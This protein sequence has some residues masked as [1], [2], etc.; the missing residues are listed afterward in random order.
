MRRSRVA[1]FSALGILSIVA[2]A[3]IVVMTIDLGRY[4]GFTENLVSD[5]LGRRFEIRGTFK[6]ELGRKIL[7]V[8][9]D[10]HLESGDWTG[11][12]D[13]MSI[14]HLDS[15]IDALSFFQGPIMIESLRVSDARVN[16]EKAADGQ[17]NWTF[18]GGTN[19]PEEAA[20]DHQ[21]PRLGA[22]P[23]MIR[24]L[25]IS[26]F[27]LSYADP[28]MQRPLAISVDKLT[29]LVDD[30][31]EVKLNLAGA[32]N[33]TPFSIAAVAA[34]VTRLVSLQEISATLRGDL[35]EIRFESSAEIDHLLAPRLP[36]LKLLVQG[37][38]AEY[39]TDVIGIER[40][41]TGPLRLDVSVTPSGQ[42]LV[43][44]ALGN[45]GEFSVD[46]KGHVVDLGNF[47]DI[48]VEAKA[49]GP[50][51]ATIGKLLGNDNFPLDPY[52]LDVEATI[53]GSNIQ[54][55]PLHIEIGV[56]KL[57]AS[58]SIE[59]FPSPDG[60]SAKVHVSG[61]DFGKFNKL[62]GLPGR[63]TGPFSLDA[64]V[65]A[66]PGRKADVSLNAKAHDLSLS[67]KG[68]WVDA[69]GFAGSTVDITASGPRFDTV[70][71]TLDVEKSPPDAFE[72]Q[73][74]LEK[75]QSSSAI[76][77]GR[78]R[79]GSDN[80]KITG[81][82]G[83][84]PLRS[85]TNLQ[86]ELA[87]P[88][89]R[90]TLRS[91][92]A[93]AERLPATEWST[94]G[95]IQWD[96]G[97]LVLEQVHTIIGSNREYLL[98]VESRVTEHPSYLGS[99]AKISITGAEF[100]AVAEVGGVLKMPDAR[101]QVTG[102][103]ERVANGYSVSDGK[104]QLGGDSIGIN[105][106]IGDRPLRQGT[107]VT[108]Q[109]SIAEFRETLAS[110][111]LP[112]DNVPPGPLNARGRL[113]SQGDVFV[114]RNVNAETSDAILTATGHLGSF[115]EL[116]GTDV[117]LNVTGKDLSR[118][119]PGNKALKA[120][121]NSFS[122]KSKIQISA[123]EVSFKGLDGKFD[124]S[125]LRGAASVSRDPFL[126]HGRFE[127]HADT[128]DF[129]L[130]LQRY[131]GQVTRTGI[132]MTLVA[133]GDWDRN[134]WSFDNF[135]FTLGEG[136]LAI[137]GALDGPPGFERTDL[138]VD[139][140]V[141]NARN[142][143]PIVDRDFPE[144]SIDLHARLIGATDRMTLQ[145]FAATIGDSEIDGEFSMRG[146]AKP[147][148][149]IRMASK[150]LDLSGYL[151][152]HEESPVEPK[153]T[154]KDKVLPDTP[155]NLE[156]LHKLNGKVDVR[157]GEL[158]MPRRTVRNIVLVGTLDD[159]LMKV[160]DFKLTSPGDGSL[161]A[162]FVLQDTGSGA[163]VTLNLAGNKL[164]LGLP[165]AT[166]DEVKSLPL[167]DVD[168][169]LQGS[170]DTVAQLAGSLNGFARVVL[171]PGKVRATAMGMFTQ[172]F[173]SQVLN[174]V[175]PFARTDPYTNVKCAVLLVEARDGNLTGDPAL[176][177]QT[178]K[179][180]IFAKADIKLKTE[181]LNVSVNTVPQTGLGL[182]LSNLVTPLTQISGTLAKPT[183]ALDA[184]GAIIQG[185]AAV[186]TAGISFLATR[187]R[188]RYLSEKDAC[189]KAIGDTQD[190]F[191]K[192]Q[193]Q[194]SVVRQ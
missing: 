150:H 53:S 10:V 39:L 30:T 129:G 54:L 37:P 169:A 103:I 157:I 25:D 17:N 90:K 134:F 57:D 153:S 174:T 35:G 69:P 65:D 12:K 3:V 87:G 178:D 51:A 49:S 132:P 105:G 170:G 191:A 130:F 2:I 8:A 14:G 185:G 187:F 76:S 107:D 125:S 162:A 144:E 82:I 166:Q 173:L 21:E 182:S 85:D 95:G 120:T 101:F 111:G 160:S 128:P 165:A 34:D 168:T 167:Y 15:T 140:N 161:S 143:G 56:T 164:S 159:G 146:G 31:G 136:R 66:L 44:S 188:D 142:L 179:L 23:L 122:M 79:V 194:Y 141:A 61:P 124:K 135:L 127:V 96:N 13:F 176:V 46:A 97:Q 55:N 32:V 58:A 152:P 38:N 158:V 145:E 88:N 74:S 184:E 68:L 24:Q 45:F 109:L 80:L 16:L 139:L 193:E 110:F 156:L 123:E 70:M 28:A 92:G 94:R 84:K 50:N 6:L 106:L 186:A 112:V 9:E 115:P 117:D 189:G 62:F 42:Y 190:E 163:S 171:G 133:S 67:L 98:D 177:V 52:Q 147:S 148:V 36:T 71:K 83:D 138:V 33:Q 47:D 19:A 93:N 78:F 11:E 59:N 192:L 43:M 131:S 104:I 155:L 89:F 102:D 64:S 20:V 99:T 1:L 151:P 175:N 40:I 63:L 4:K 100:G 81:Q 119:L 72:L 7:L 114:L 18:A 75:A 181:K 5:A 29:E 108:V 91:F 26:N 126:E 116:I 172:D 118:L 113:L 180:N 41:T 27:R 22:L 48:Y 77:N 121:T 137:K 60:A 73:L 149:D 154:K 183:L 86:F